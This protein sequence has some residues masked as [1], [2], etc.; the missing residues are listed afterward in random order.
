MSARRGAFCLFLSTTKKRGGTSA[1]SFTEKRKQLFQLL[2]VRAPAIFAN[3]ESFSE[4]N[5]AGFV[6]SVKVRKL[7]SETVC[8]VFVTL[9]KI[10]A[11]LGMTIPLFSRVAGDQIGRTIGAPFV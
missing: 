9:F 10:A 2:H 11:H 6:L 1:F 8:L 5:V 4:A 7:C 3:L